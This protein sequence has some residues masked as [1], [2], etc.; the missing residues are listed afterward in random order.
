MGFI[1]INK[2]KT[3]ASIAFVITSSPSN[4]FTLTALN[5]IQNALDNYKV[6][7]VFFYQKGVLN[8]SRLLTAP[9]DEYPLMEQW[10]VLA[11]KNKVP[12]YLCATAAEKYGLLDDLSIQ[13]NVDI[14]IPSNIAPYFTVAGLGE[15]VTLSLAADR[16]IQL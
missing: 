11:L 6:V 10:K 3:L 2:E 16:V 9:S 12:L 7:G 14:E 1:N 13:N 15:L 8:A 4:N 5:L